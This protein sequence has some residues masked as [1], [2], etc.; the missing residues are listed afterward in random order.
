MT[1]VSAY[2]TSKDSENQTYNE[3]KVN[4]PNPEMTHR[5]DQQTRA[6]EKPN[7]CVQKRHTSENTKKALQNVQS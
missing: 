6:S 4:H 1:P 2:Q 3:Q 7:N 5:V